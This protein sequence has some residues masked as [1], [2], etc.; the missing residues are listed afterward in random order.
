MVAGAA[1]GCRLAGAMFET[2]VEVCDKHLLF[3]TGAFSLVELREPDEVV[4][5]FIGERPW[6]VKA[7]A[8]PALRG[9]W[10]ADGLGAARAFGFPHH[11]IVRRAV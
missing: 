8:G 1:I 7:L 4:F 3:M 5:R 9:P 11:F 10:C 6:I 2:A